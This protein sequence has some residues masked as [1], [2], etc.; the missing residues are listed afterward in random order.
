MM[1]KL[2]YYCSSRNKRHFEDHL[3]QNS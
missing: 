1:L 3:S 2:Q